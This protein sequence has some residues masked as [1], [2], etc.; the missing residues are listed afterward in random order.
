MDKTLD[1]P[2]T[3]EHGPKFIDILDSVTN[4]YIRISVANGTLQLNGVSVIVAPAVLLPAGMVVPNPP[5]LVFSSRVGINSVTDTGGMN[6]GNLVPKGCIA[7]II[8]TADGPISSP[9]K[10]SVVGLSNSTVTLYFTDTNDASIT[11]S[12]VPFCAVVF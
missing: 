8:D 7:G 6:T 10:V 12:E 1:S 4:K 11:N 3:I 5:F 2:S 9:Y